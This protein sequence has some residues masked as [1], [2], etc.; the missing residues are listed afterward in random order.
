MPL[1]PD[2]VRV[3]LTGA[4]YTA[5]K[6]TAQPSDAT[7]SWPTGWVDLGWISEDGVTEAYD[8]NVAEIKAW[9][10]GTTVR[11]VISSSIATLQ[12]TCIET[13]PAVVE[14]FHKGSTVTA[15]RLDVYAPTADERS[16]GLDVVDGDT[17][18]RLLI[19]RGEVSDRGDV[20]YKSDEAVGYDMTV[21]AYPDDTGLVLVKLSD[22]VAW[23]S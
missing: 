9:Q 11:R 3:A 1:D 6:G 22:D 4:V 13:K 2:N 18:L 19:P 15:G 20:V 5:P 8:D 21:T 14:A 16:F 7:A 23:S 17:H 10:G 12:F